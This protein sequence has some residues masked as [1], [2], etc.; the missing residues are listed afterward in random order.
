MVRVKV[1]TDAKE[2]FRQSSPGGI[3]TCPFPL[4][5]ILKK[6]A[7]NSGSSEFQH[8]ECGSSPHLQRH[9]YRE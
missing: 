3:K 4:R 6:G 1:P 2:F 5:R 9:T 8:G 7:K